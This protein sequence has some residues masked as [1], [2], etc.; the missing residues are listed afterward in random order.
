[1]T[2]QTAPGAGRLDDATG[3]KNMLLL[4]Q[5]RWIAVIGQLITIEI[6]FYSLNVVL[7]IELMLTALGFLLLFNLASLLR[8]RIRRAV[9]NREVFVSLLVD[10]MILTVQLYLSGGASNPFVFLYLLQVTLGAVLLKPA[11]TWT[12]LGIT[13]C[14]FV[15]L[16]WFA[17]PLGLR[18]DHDHGLASLYIQGMLIC[19]VLNAVL[20]VTFITRIGHNLRERDAR[21]ASLRQRAAEEEHIVRMGLLASGAAHELGTPLATLAVILGDWRRMP[22]FT[23]DA[24]LRQEVSEMQTQVL[25]CKS[26]V[27]SILLSAGEAR[28]ESSAATTLST[29]LNDLVQEWRISHP[30]AELQYDGHFGHDLAVVSDSAVKQMIFNM[31]ENAFESSGAWLQLDVARQADELVLSCIDNGPGFTAATLAQL[32]QPYNT[33]KGRPGGGLGLFLVFNVARTLGGEVR[34]ANRAGGGACVTIR[35]PLSALT[36]DE[37]DGVDKKGIA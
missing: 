12:M 6:A 30:R 16:A 11:Y 31:L 19:F 8:V 9:K 4:I 36:L 13:A 5:L 14:C 26:I 22:A 10:V 27:S 7:P 33:S 34:A 17:L 3:R 15:A 2:D 28:G 37:D 1:M 21:L 20:L 24:E 25:R 29:F 18:P 32:G 23:S 35:L